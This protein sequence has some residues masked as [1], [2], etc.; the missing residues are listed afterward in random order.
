M[1]QF[2]HSIPFALILVFISLGFFMHSSQLHAQVSFHTTQL[3]HLAPLGEAADTSYQDVWGYVDANT[4][5]EY[6]LLCTSDGISIIDVSDPTNPIEVSRIG[7]PAFAYDVKSFGNY[8]ATNVGEII[9][10]SDP[11][12]PVIIGTFDPSH[13]IY[14]ELPYLYGACPNYIYNISDPTN[15]VFVANYGDDC[16]DIT[17]INDTAYV[18]SGRSGTRII[19]MVDKDNLI[20]LGSF[21]LTGEYSHNAWPTPDRHYMF[22]TDEVG[23]WGLTVWDISDYS[24]INMVAQYKL[25]PFPT[26]HNAF[27]KSQYAYISHYADG[28]RILDILD[29]TNPVEVGFYDTFLGPDDVPFAGNWGVYAFAPSGNIYISDRIRGLFLV[30]FDSV[31][32]GGVEGVVSDVTTGLP[33]PGATLHFLEADK[34]ADGNGD[35]MYSFHSAE[36][37]HHFIAVAPGYLESDSLAVTIVSG[38]TAILDITLQQFITISVDMIPVTLE[39][40]ESATATFEVTNLALDSLVFSIRDI[41]GPL[42]PTPGALKSDGRARMAFMGAFSNVKWS[43]HETSYKIQGD[44]ISTGSTL[45]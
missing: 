21:S 4:G 23:P 24:N 29:P 9:D 13:N 22:L 8:I 39:L 19:N 26:I 41:N 32:S 42:P 10:V 17:V 20:T 44:P 12:N 43:Q 30:A 33:I 18:G 45:R 16:H 28:L 31:R 35:G 3:G 40:G 5:V 37:E 34:S 15:P 2:C 14:I 1:K 27:L 36:G 25:H 11:V 7:T 38:D 6:A